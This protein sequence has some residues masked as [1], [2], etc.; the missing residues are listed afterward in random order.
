MLTIN[1]EDTK[2]HIIQF[3]DKRIRK[4]AA[5]LLDPGMVENGVVM[6]KENVSRRIQN[7][8]AEKSFS[9]KEAIVGINSVHTIYRVVSLPHIDK[10]LANDAASYELE[11]A[12]PISLDELYTSWQAFDVSDTETLLC[13]I[14][15]PRTSIDSILGTLRL[16]D[17]QPRGMEITPLALARTADEKNAV[18]LNIQALSFD[19]IVISNGIPLLLRSVPFPSNNIPSTEKTV[20]IKEELDRTVSFYNSAH[21]EA[22]VTPETVTYL[23][24]KKSDIKDELAGYTVK[25]IPVWMDFPDEID[26]T[27]YSVNIGLA[28]RHLRDIRTPLKITI[29]STPSAYLPKSRSFG[30]LLPWLILFIGVCVLIPMFMLMQES[31]GKTFNLKQQLIQLESQVK[32]MQ[33][34]SNWSKQTQS[35][36]DAYKEYDAFT[37]DIMDTIETMR[38]RV[39]LDLG[40]ITGHLPGTIDLSLINYSKDYTATLSGFSPDKDTVLDYTKSLRDSGRFARVILADMREVE[41][42]KWSFTLQLQ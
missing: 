11:R 38:Q 35:R 22:P 2:I 14:G 28:L 20:M 5:I 9:D 6:D 24:G 17:I 3:N 4:A 25:L 16:A 29:D 23:S 10:K 42:G 7:V 26:S 37:Q 32:N 15:I 31:I 30:E 21:S 19:I 8:L 33:M 1:I 18:I 36:I 13:M 40:Q 34:V 41:Y 39:N 12:M 27:E